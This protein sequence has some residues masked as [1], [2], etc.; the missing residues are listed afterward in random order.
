MGRGYAY[1]TLVV[2]TVVIP[3]GDYMG[4]PEYPLINEGVDCAPHQGPPVMSGAAWVHAWSRQT[5]AAPEHQL[6]HEDA[7]MDNTPLLVPAWSRLL[8][9]HP[10]RE[11]V[12]F[13]LRGVREGFRIGFSS[14]LRRLR[15]ARRNIPSA[16]IALR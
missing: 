4:D 15:S 13:I 2:I 16:L 10:D 7:C 8:H 3:P 5:A 1:H 14:P 11:L 6:V 9:G 12:Y